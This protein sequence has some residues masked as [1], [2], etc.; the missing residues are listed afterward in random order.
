MRFN[1]CRIQKAKSSFFDQNASVEQSLYDPAKILNSISKERSQDPK[2]IY[3]RDNDQKNTLICFQKFAHN[4][5]LSR[6]SVDYP[7]KSSWPACIW[8]TQ[9]HFVHTW[10]FL[11]RIPLSSVLL[12]AF[13][14]DKTL[15]LVIITY[16][17]SQFRN[18]TF[19]FWFVIYS[20]VCYL[21]IEC[22]FAFLPESELDFC[23]ISV[24]SVLPF[25]LKWRRCA[26]LFLYRN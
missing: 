22:H 25:V 10:C 14:F 23:A 16:L 1:S 26:K 9:R 18:L 20:S 12:N 21:V 4:E 8:T 17:W 6:A 13:L 19:C 15:C 7:T 11:F 3:L 5:I 2:S 24:R